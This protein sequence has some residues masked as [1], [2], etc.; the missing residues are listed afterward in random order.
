MTF[1]LNAF[2][3]DRRSDAAAYNPA[4]GDFMLNHERTERFELVGDR[5]LAKYGFAPERLAGMLTVYRGRLTLETNP[6]E[7][8]FFNPASRSTVSALDKES[9]SKRLGRLMGELTGK[10]VQSQM[11]RTLFLSWFDTKRPSMKDRKH[12]ARWMMHTVEK[13]M[14][15]YSKKAPVG[16]KR[17]RLGDEQGGGGYIRFSDM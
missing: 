15:T 4:D 10:I 1:V 17:G 8:L 5:V 7:Y 6:H 12:L 3:N 9:L 2:K 11:F 14:D 16:E 13:Q